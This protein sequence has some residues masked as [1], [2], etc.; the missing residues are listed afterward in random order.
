[1]NISKKSV[2][3]GLFMMISLFQLF[4]C[5]ELSK[6]TAKTVTNYLEKKYGEEFIVT[7]IGDRLNNNTTKLYVKPAK[8]EMITFTAYIDAKDNIIEDYVNN[9]ILSKV[10]TEVQKLFSKSGIDCAVNLVITNDN[11]HET[12]RDLS[13]DEFMNKN[14]IDFLFMRLIIDNSTSNKQEITEILKQFKSLYPID[15]KIDVYILPTDTFEECKTDFLSY[16]SVNSTRIKSYSPIT[17]FQIMIEDGIKS[18]LT[19]ESLEKSEGI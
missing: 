17:N 12:D 10:E 15:C 19:N 1:M 5:S 8:N 7:H 16:P 2:K 4:A 11:I 18:E 3:V 6:K 9:I 14:N 13:I